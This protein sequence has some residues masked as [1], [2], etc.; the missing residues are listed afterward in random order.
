MPLPGVHDVFQ[1]EWMDLKESSQALD[2]ADIVNTHD[3]QP[4]DCGCFLVSRA[5]LD[6]NIFLLV[7]MSIVIV[8]DMDLDPVCPF[9]PDVNEGARWKSSLVRRLLEES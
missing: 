6:A 2:S 1:Y 9:L 5:V 8:K 7:E 4:G 3:I